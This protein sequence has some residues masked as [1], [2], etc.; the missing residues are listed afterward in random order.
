MESSCPDPVVTCP[1]SSA[2]SHHP[3]L[4]FAVCA[5]GHLD[6][7]TQGYGEAAQPFTLALYVVFWARVWLCPGPGQSLQHTWQ[8]EPPLSLL[9]L[10][11]FLTVPLNQ[12]SGSAQGYTALTGK[13]RSPSLFSP[14]SQGLKSL[15]R[16][17]CF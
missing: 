12:M 5:E 1:S 7:G 9:F 10:F 16:L 13:D 15:L 11:L 8:T 3:V 2:Y 17:P 6:R 14:Q 4:H